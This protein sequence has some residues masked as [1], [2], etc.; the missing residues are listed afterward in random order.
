VR[1]AVFADEEFHA[2]LKE[3]GAD[4]IGSPDLLL[5]IAN[6]TLNF[7]KIIATPE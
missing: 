2:Q 3:A 6:G 5:E 7:D 1:V 4:T